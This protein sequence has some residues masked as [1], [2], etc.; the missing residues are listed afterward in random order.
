MRCRQMLGTW[1]R[2]NRGVALAAGVLLSLLGGCNG[3]LDPSEVT[4]GPDSGRL[5]VPI[6]S[7]I[8]PLDEVNPEFG[9]AEDVKPDDLK[10]IATD[11]V[12]GP[13]DLITVSIYD[14]VNQGVETV[15]SSRVSDTG[16][17]SLPMLS[18]PLAASGMTEAQLQKMIAQK[19]KEAALLPNAQV[20]VTV[21]EAR[22]RTFWIAGSVT[23][24]QQ[25]AMVETDYRLMQALTTA[26]GVTFPSEYLYVIRKR[27]SEKPATRPVSDEKL[28]VP[29]QQPA[30][31]PTDLAP[32]TGGS[33]SLQPVLAMAD[34]AASKAEPAGES[35]AGNE[36]RFGTVEGKAVLIGADEPKVE[37]AAP[38][39][40]PTLE[41]VAAQPAQ[42]A[43][44][45]GTAASAEEERR[46][47][48]VPLQS[49]QD[50][51]LRYNIVIR[52]NDL[53]YVP[54][55]QAGVYYM[56]GHVA[57]PGAYNLAGQK[58]SLANAVVAARGLD[59][60]AVPAR[61][62]LYR[63][64]AADKQLLVRVDLGK[65]FA[66][67]QPD[68]FLKPNDMVL[69]GTDIYS[70]FLAALRGAFRITYGFGFLY[71]RNYA[72]AQTTRYEN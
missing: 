7:S 49:L 63:R 14:L 67:T 50:G 34:G 29:P 26:G 27:S 38:A 8:D 55:P 5:V 33:G 3:F 17:L 11:Y 51:D 42:P 40:A 13:T 35:T 36:E 68:I 45:F 46:I 47:I 43:Y 65:I 16:M 54:V 39:A 69:V 4:R 30:T 19:Y 60:L 41:A 20:A 57:A 2:T 59:Q 23:R 6:L 15:R 31:E 37:E 62:D 12:I 52:P 24:P 64:V 28:V 72:P 22:G 61:T 21:N 70:S 66:G 25:Y 1:G 10:V 44:E 71:D 18:E 9:S 32:Q 48:R 58:I 53:I 56:G